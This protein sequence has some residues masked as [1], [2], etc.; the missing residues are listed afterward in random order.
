LIDSWKYSLLRP[1]CW[2]SYQ[3]RSQASGISPDSS[4]GRYELNVWFFNIVHIYS[5]YVQ[6]LWNL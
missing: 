5:I 4:C 1:V 6:I 3:A 2:E